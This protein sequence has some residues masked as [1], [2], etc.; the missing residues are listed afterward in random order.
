MSIA[1]AFLIANNGK[2]IPQSLRK[3]DNYIFHW[4]GDCGLK[5]KLETPCRFAQACINERRRRATSA[6]IGAEA[7]VDGGR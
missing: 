2:A 7:D 5:V 4:F 3:V 1:P 6:A